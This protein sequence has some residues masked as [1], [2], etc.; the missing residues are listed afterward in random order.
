MEIKIEDKYKKWLPQFDRELFRCA[1]EKVVSSDKQGIKDT[2]ISESK[3]VT[4]TDLRHAAEHLVAPNEL[5]S[6]AVDVR[7]EIDLRIG[8]AF[9][10][11]QT[12]YC[13]NSFDI[14]AYKE[15]NRNEKNLI[16]YG[17]CQFPTLGFVVDRYWRNKQ[18]IPEEFYSIHV[19]VR[20]SEGNAQFSW[21]RIR[22]F[23]RLTCIVLYEICLEAEQ[24]LIKKV[25]QKEKKKLKPLPLTTVT[26]QKQTSRLYRMSAKQTVDVAEK[27]YQQGYISYPRTETDRF[28]DEQEIKRIVEILTH[29]SN[30]GQYAQR[31]LSNGEYASPR[32][33]QHDDHSHPPIHPCKCNNGSQLQGA[34][35]MSVDE[36]RV[37]EYICR[38][39]LACCSKDALGAET[40]VIGQ[41]GTETFIC[42]GLMVLERNYLE[43]FTDE[44]WKSSRSN[45]GSHFL[46][47][48]SIL[49]SIRWP[50]TDVT[51]IFPVSPRA[52]HQISC[53]AHPPP[54]RLVLILASE[55]SACAIA[56]ATEGFSATLKNGAI[57]S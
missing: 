53:T 10:R 50:A 35:N 56:V 39:F 38:H 19:E 9:T 7:Q 42:R 54:R 28:G 4:P 13:Q 29:H 48:S 14:Y 26:L 8:S 21:E 23:D 43:I 6:W 37:Y 15:E 12:R 18:F 32:G 17:P 20:T 25:I 31:L 46:Y 27:L 49:I 44:K 1:I 33:G 55:E 5:D 47:L 45:Y 41:M 51:I 30:Y 2:L 57:L 52:P 40:T 22:L 24:I 3:N 16:S 34:D 11:L 36:K